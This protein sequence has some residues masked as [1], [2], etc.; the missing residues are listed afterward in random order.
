M[1]HDEDYSCFHLYLPSIA[2]STVYGISCVRQ[3]RAED[4]LRK[5]SD[6]TRSTVQKAVVVLANKPIFGPI[7]DKLGVITRAFFAQRD[8]E[9][10]EILEHFYHSLVHAL[11]DEE[12]TNE[13]AISMGMSIREIVFKFRMQ[14]LTLFKLLLL[15][16]RV[17]FYSNQVEKLCS[18]QYALVSLVPLLLL[19][20]VDAASPVLDSRSASMSKASSLRSSDRASLLAYLGLP[21]N[22]FGKGAFF[23]PYLPLQQMDMLQSDSYLVG[24]TNSIFRSQRDCPLDVIVNLEAATIEYLNPKVATMILGILRILTDPLTWAIKHQ[25]TGCVVNSKNISLLLSRL[26]SLSTS[27]L[28]TKTCLYSL[29][30]VIR[31]A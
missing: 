31:L 16:K 21:L 27:L 9:E 19:H 11:K 4:L 10:T 18:F 13:S 15:Q 17:M 30:Q 29:I 20:L 8:F 25:T 6:V 22:L 3:L 12:Q 1:Q 5:S 14:T 2:E 7:R 26:S 24:A 28:G 23:Q